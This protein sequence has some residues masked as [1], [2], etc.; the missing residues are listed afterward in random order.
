MINATVTGRLGGDAEMKQTRNGGSM[1]RFNI[2]SDQG[3]GD[4]KTTNWVGA[5]V[6]GKQAENLERL[7]V[8]GTFVIVRGEFKTRTDESTGKT[9]L[10]ITADNVQLG[11]RV[12]NED[13][14][15]KP[16]APVGNSSDIPF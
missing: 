4:H 16:Y 7:L 9:Y 11:P 12:R 14:S 6:F 2:A 13:G 5:A 1:L 3:W 10:D 15:T 8:K